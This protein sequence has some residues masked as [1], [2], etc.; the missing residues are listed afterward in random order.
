MRWGGEIGQFDAPVS[1]RAES[2]GLSDNN[3]TVP[4]REK[5]SIYT[6]LA[7]LFNSLTLDIYALSLRA[8][9]R[10]EIVSVETRIACGKKDRRAC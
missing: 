4:T 6:P 10:I 7:R 2:P 8:K 5:V 1:I 9:L 3:A